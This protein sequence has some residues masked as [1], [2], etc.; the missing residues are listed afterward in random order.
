MEAKKNKMGQGEQGDWHFLTGG[1][2]IRRSK[3]LGNALG[4]VSHSWSKA[5]L[6]GNHK[7]GTQTPPLASLT[8]PSPPSVILSP[9]NTG[10]SW[11]EAGRDSCF[12]SETTKSWHGASFVSD[13]TPGLGGKTCFV[14]FSGSWQG[15]S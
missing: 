12:K 14:L 4:S 6:G 15:P 10:A 7:V 8:P 3:Q 2:C 11:A 13:G 5:I 9:P 1:L